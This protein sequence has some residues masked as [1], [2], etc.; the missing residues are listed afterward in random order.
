M[1]PENTGLPNH[2]PVSVKEK[3]NLNLFISHAYTQSVRSPNY[4]NSLFHGGD[5][6]DVQ[7]VGD[8]LCH[9]MPQQTMSGPWPDSSDSLL[10]FIHASG[11]GVI[12]FLWPGLGLFFSPLR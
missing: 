4:G 8:Q 7:V 2:R 5:F 1:E 9:W 11:F 3:S 10:P 12:F 6:Q